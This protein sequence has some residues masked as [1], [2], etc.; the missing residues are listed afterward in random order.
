M[1][2]LMYCNFHISS[3][4]SFSELFGA[5]KVRLGHQ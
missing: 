4:T 2:F 3:K 5:W 1:I